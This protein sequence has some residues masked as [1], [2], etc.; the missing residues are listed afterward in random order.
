MTAYGAF[1]Y[2][3]SR[4]EWMTSS[5]PVP[6]T[7]APKI[8]LV[9]AST[10][11]FIKPWVSPF[12]TARATRAIGRYGDLGAPLAHTDAPRVEAH[13]NA[14]AFENVFHRGGDVL[15][16]AT[17]QT[18]PHFDDRD[19]TAKA[20]IHLAELKAYVAAAHDDQMARKE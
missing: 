16:F 5:P 11:I 4:I 12:S 13:V 19:L 6:R 9:S 18:R 10:R 2:M 8:S 17:D 3:T 7:A 1:A 14:F 20:P 15:V